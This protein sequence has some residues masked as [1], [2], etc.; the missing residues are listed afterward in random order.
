[1][2]SVNPVT[3]GSAETLQGSMPWWTAS[4]AALRNGMPSAGIRRPPS[5]EIEAGLDD[6]LAQWAD[7]KPM[8]DTVVAG[9]DLDKESAAR[10]FNNFNAMM[11]TMNEVVG[12]YTIATQR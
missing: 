10:K 11:A 3:T 5:P 4:W 7:I 6:V 2:L 1:M 9:S 8:L 12:M